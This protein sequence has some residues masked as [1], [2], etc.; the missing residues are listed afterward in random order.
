MSFNFDD[1]FE[2]QSSDEPNH[3]VA[4]KIEYDTAHAADMTRRYMATHNGFEP[5]PH[6]PSIIIPG[7]PKTSPLP[8]A[9]VQPPF[10]VVPITFWDNIDAQCLGPAT[11]LEDNHPRFNRNLP[12]CDHS[13]VQSIEEVIDPTL[14]QPILIRSTALNYMHY[15]DII[16]ASFSI[17]TYEPELLQ[18]QWFCGGHVASYN[19]ISVP[20]CNTDVT[21]FNYGSTAG[22]WR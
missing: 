21:S 12:L 1:D 8:N 14:S 9:L 20:S 10:K 18:N 4:P 16:D 2:Y 3:W 22:C 15:S 17:D 5:F 6:Q 11:D 13:I 7:L 19:S